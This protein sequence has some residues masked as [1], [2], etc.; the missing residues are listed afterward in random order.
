MCTGTPSTSP[1]VVTGTPSTCP[2][3]VINLES[4]NMVNYIFEFPSR[5]DLDV[6]CFKWNATRS[7]FT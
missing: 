6:Y 3:V 5:V 4:A 1:G 2:G 7:V